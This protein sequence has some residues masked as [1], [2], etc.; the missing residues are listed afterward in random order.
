MNT[1]DLT[2]REIELLTYHQCFNYYGFGGPIKVPATA[3]YAHKIA[4][5]AYDNGFNARKETTEVNPALFNQLH[6][7]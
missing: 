2:K 1:T 6:F 4:Y 5:Y 7:L 3:F